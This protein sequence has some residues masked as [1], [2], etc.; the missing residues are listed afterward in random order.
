MQWPLMPPSTGWK[1]PD[2]SAHEADDSDPQ[3]F[4]RAEIQRL[5]YFAHESW[6]L[7]CSRDH[8]LGGDNWCFL[9]RRVA[10]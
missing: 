7:K 10:S 2:L 8:G 3:G 1:K 6:E 5:R 4:H 9:T